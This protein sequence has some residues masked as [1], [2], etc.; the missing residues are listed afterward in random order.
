[1]QD[2]VEGMSWKYKTHLEF[3]CIQPVNFFF[4]PFHDVFEFS[5][6]ELLSG[7]QQKMVDVLGSSEWKCVKGTAEKWSSADLC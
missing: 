6:V 3:K 2:N 5:P 4:L 1:M 7:H